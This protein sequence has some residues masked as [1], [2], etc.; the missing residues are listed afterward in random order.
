MPTKVYNAYEILSWNVYFA[1]SHK[2]LKRWRCACTI[3]TLNVKL[4]IITL[5]MLM[6]TRYCLSR[7][8][9]GGI[10]ECVVIKGTPTFH[11]GAPSMKLFSSPVWTILKYTNEQIQTEI[12]QDIFDTFQIFL[13]LLNPIYDYGDV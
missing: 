11:K 4:K 13:E 7:N 1:A 8:W 2:K 9:A 6:H 10:S 12:R 5:N 3:G